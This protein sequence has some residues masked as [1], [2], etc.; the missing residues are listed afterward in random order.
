[1]AVMTSPNVWYDQCVFVCICVCMLQP[2]K[3]TH[4]L[5]TS[6]VVNVNIIVFLKVNESNL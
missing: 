1:M 6:D 3:K 4:I 2:P 5:L